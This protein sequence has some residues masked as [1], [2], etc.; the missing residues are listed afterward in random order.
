VSF[1]VLDHALAGCRQFIAGD[2]GGND[3]SNYHVTQLT[4]DF[5]DLMMRQ[6]SHY[7]SP[8][9]RAKLKAFTATEAA[10]FARGRRAG[11]NIV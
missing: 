6:F 8:T 10:G 4:H 1:P 3:F 7:S 11:L 2:S 5:D 9:E